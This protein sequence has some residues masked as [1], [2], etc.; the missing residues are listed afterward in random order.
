MDHFQVPVVLPGP[1]EPPTLPG[2]QA[3]VGLVNSLMPSAAAGQFD[4]T[5]LYTLALF[6]LRC[7]QARSVLGAECGRL[8][9]SVAADDATHLAEG[10]RD[11]IDEAFGAASLDETGR[12]L[13]Q[14]VV[15]CQ[16]TDD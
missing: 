11:L 3:F 5:C 4:H 13:L 8:V 7:G 9:E 10:V 15:Q 1:A 2:G 6:L 14:A 12:L 16:R